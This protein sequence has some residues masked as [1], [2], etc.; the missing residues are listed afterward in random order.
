MLSPGLVEI[1]LR[2][3]TN[4]G[5]G[6]RSW[7]IR[8]GG[9]GLG[10]DDPMLIRLG[11][12]P[13]APIAV[14]FTVPISLDGVDDAGFCDASFFDSL[15]GPGNAKA[16]GEPTLR[17]ICETAISWLEG[18]HLNICNIDDEEE[19]KR[20]QESWTKAEQHTAN[21]L[22][23]IRRY[24]EIMGA[25]EDT[26]LLNNDTDDD[27][28]DNN[29][30]A[31]NNNILLEWVVPAFRPCFEESSE[32]SVFV[33]C[34]WQSLVTR[35]GPGIYAFELFT[36]AFCDLLVKEID[37]FE[38][39]RLPCRRPNTMNRLGL[40]VND[41]GFEPLMTDLLERLIA[42]MCQALYPEEIHTSALDHHHSFVVRYRNDSSLKQE[43]GNK[44]LDMH[45]DASEATLNVCLGRDPLP[46]GGLRFCGRYGDPNHRVNSVV[47]SHTKGWA[48]LHL[49]RHRHG[50]D[51]IEGGERMNLIVWA[52]NSAFRG[53]A[54]FGHV[55]LDGSPRE[56]EVG[57]PDLLCLSKANDGDYEQQIKR[58]GGT[59]HDPGANAG[60]G[61]QEADAKRH[62][63]FF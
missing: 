58:F 4:N 52:R 24:Q 47:H 38:A 37:F 12:D 5:Y 7:S 11:G 8:V 51:N 32:T 26:S 39:S 13:R 44:G 40:V 29:D 35:V 34:N 54:A 60:A 46:G 53:A 22:N 14:R 3:V 10:D 61:A 16:K 31:V 48:V 57:E 33:P 17:S 62:R 15:S 27:D 25:S 43:D 9:A 18:S 2:A 42:P 30:N 45:H 56:K 41:I 36:Q 21:R 6:S 50:A 19:L 28:D 59:N 20:R 55:P 63:V 23:V 49:G 1:T